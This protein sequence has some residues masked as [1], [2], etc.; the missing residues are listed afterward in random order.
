MAATTTRTRHLNGYTYHFTYVDS[1]NP[2]GLDASG[3][4]YYP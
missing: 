2:Y 4:T 1:N 3:N